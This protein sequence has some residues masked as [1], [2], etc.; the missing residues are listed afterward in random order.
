[1]CEQTEAHGR[2][3]LLSDL[4]EGLRVGVLALVEGLWPS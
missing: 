1:M 4:V 3:P 2:E